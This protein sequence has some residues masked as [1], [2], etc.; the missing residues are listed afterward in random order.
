MTYYCWIIGDIETH[1]NCDDYAQFVS[2][3][4]HRENA[5][6]LGLYISDPYAGINGA[7]AMSHIVANN[8]EKYDCSFRL[9]QSNDLGAYGLYY[10]GT[11]YNWGL[12]ESDE[13]GITTLTE[14]GRE[15]YMISTGI[16]SRQNRSIIRNIRARKSYPLKF[17]WN[18][19]R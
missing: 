16:I 18:G 8:K 5:L 10:A 13:K 12:I 11:I 7:T 3:F 9:M 15:L 4:I 1:E 6:A 2:A 17:Y 19:H 14:S